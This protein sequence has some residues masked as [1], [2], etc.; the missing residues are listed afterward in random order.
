[1]TL[2]DAL[3]AAVSRAVAP[4]AADLSAVLAELAE[5][6]R[7]QPAR[8]VSVADAAREMG[9]SECSVRRHIADGSLPCRRV[10]ARVLVD[11]TAALPATADKISAMAREARR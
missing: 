9:I 2:D 3:A 1:M 6:R 10:G 4:L 8:L 11:M 7:T 5:M